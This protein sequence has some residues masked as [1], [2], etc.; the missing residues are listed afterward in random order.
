MVPCVRVAIGN[1]DR[2]HI[3]TAK[4]SLM[5]A[6]SCRQLGPGAGSPLAISV[7]M[8]LGGPFSQPDEYELDLSIAILRFYFMMFYFAGWEW[9]K[10]RELR[11]PECKC[12]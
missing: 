12:M 4:E 8:G 10:G 11:N 9:E 1:Q 6:R 3:V 5:P 7:F 2:H